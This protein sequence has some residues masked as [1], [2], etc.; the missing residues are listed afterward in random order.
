MPLTLITRD[1]Q[2]RDISRIVQN[3]RKK[4]SRTKPLTAS[5]PPAELHRPTTIASLFHLF[6]TTATTPTTT[7]PTPSSSSTTATTNPPSSP[8]TASPSADDEPTSPP[9][10][11]EQNDTLYNRCLDG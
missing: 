2:W 10:L 6:L 11:N 5:S 1:Q 4:M 9:L 3:Q 7:T 8:T